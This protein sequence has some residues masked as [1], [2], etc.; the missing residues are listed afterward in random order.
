MPYLDSNIL[1]KIFYASTGC[2]TL[3]IGNDKSRTDLYGSTS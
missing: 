2:E 1:F 3:R